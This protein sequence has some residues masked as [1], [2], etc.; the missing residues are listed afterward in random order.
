MAQHDDRGH[1]EPSG[2]ECA[3]RE[4]LANS[5]QFVDFSP[6]L[7]SSMSPVPSPPAAHAAAMGLLVNSSETAVAGGAEVPE[8][9]AVDLQSQLPANL[10]PELHNRVLLHT[11]DRE[12]SSTHTNT[13]HI[14]ITKRNNAV[15][16]SVKTAALVSLRFTVGLTRGH[17]NF[18]V[19]NA[20]EINTRTGHADHKSCTSPQGSMR[21]AGEPAV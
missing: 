13:R 20:D 16:S 21:A 3:V 17:E 9:Q 12:K 2:P 11:P 7:T 10:A 4:Q 15:P 6:V 1:A 14:V 19:L 8:P 5:M 18:V